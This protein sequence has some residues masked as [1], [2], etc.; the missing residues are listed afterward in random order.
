MFL[1][2]CQTS[3]ATLKYGCIVLPVLSAI[4]KHKAFKQL[5]VKNGE[6]TISKGE[7]YNLDKNNKC[8]LYILVLK[9]LNLIKVSEGETI[10]LGKS[11]TQILETPFFEIVGHLLNFG[12]SNVLYNSSDSATIVLLERHCERRDYLKK[13]LPQINS[14]FV[15]AI[16]FMPLLYTLHRIY[17]QDATIQDKLLE[18][19]NKVINAIKSSLIDYGIDLSYFV[20]IENSNNLVLAQLSQCFS[21]ATYILSQSN[22]IPKAGMN[23]I[24]NMCTELPTLNFCKIV[25]YVEMINKKYAIKRIVVC[26]DVSELQ[27]REIQKWKK[28]WNLSSVIFAVTTAIVK[29]RIES[30]LGVSCIIKVI[31]NLYD[32]KMIKTMINSIPTIDRNEKML[33]IAGP[34]QYILDN[35]SI[36]KTSNKYKSFMLKW[37]EVLDSNHLLISVSNFWVKGEANTSDVLQQDNDV[38]TILP[39]E[40][41]LE[42]A[43]NYFMWRRPFSMLLGASNAGLLPVKKIM[44]HT[45]F[46]FEAGFCVTILNTVDYRI[47]MANISDLGDAISLE[48]ESWSIGMRYT[49]HDIQKRISDDSQF[50]TFILEKRGVVLA[51]LYTQRI[52]AI[53]NI[54]TVTWKTEGKIND[55]AGEILQL[56]RINARKS[57]PIAAGTLLRNFAINVAHALKIEN[58]C[59]VTRTTDYGTSDCRKTYQQ[60]ISDL[61]EKKSLN[62]KKDRGL[63]F[64]T[65]SGASM[66]KI[67]ENWRPED[68]ENEGNG[69]LILYS[70]NNMICS[71]SAIS[72]AKIVEDIQNS[73]KRIIIV[74]TSSDQI[75]LNTTW[76]DLGLNSLDIYRTTASISEAFNLALDSS[77]LFNYST[78]AS[79]TSHIVSM[80]TN[81]LTD[82]DNSGVGFLREEQVLSNDTEGVYIQGVSLNFPGCNTSLQSFWNMSLSGESISSK[83]P[84]NRWDETMIDPLLGPVVSSDVRRRCKFGAFLDDIDYFDAKYFGISENEAQNMDPHQRILLE[85]VDRALQDA[86]YECEVHGK[87]VGVFLGICDEDKPCRPANVPL[88][89]YDANAKSN[90]TAAGR[91]SY[92]YDWTGPC[93]SFDTACSSSLVALHAALSA[94]EKGECNIAVV[95]ATHL[96]L[97]PYKHVAYAKAAMTSSRGLCNSFDDNADGYLRGEGCGVLILRNISS[98]GKPM[99][100]PYAVINGVQIAQDG[101]TASLTAP[102]S[103]AQSRVIQ[104]TLRQSGVMANQV[105][106]IETH[107]TGTVLGDPIEID[108]IMNC[109]INNAKRENDLVVGCAKSNIGHLEA[110]A[111]IVGVIK[112]ILVLNSETYPP[113]ANLNILN[114]NIKSLCPEGGIIFPTEAKSK[115]TSETMYAAVSSFGYAGTIAHAILSQYSDGKKSLHESLKHIFPRKKRE[116]T[117]FLFTGQGSQYHNMGRFLFDNDEVF[118]A[119]MQ[120]CSRILE[121]HLDGIS[122][123]DMMYRDMQFNSKLLNMTKYSQPAIF[124]LG[125]SLYQVWTTRGKHADVLLGHSVGELIAACV[126]GVISLENGLKLVAKR[127]SIMQ[128]CPNT[129]GTMCAIKCPKHVLENKIENFSNVCIACCNGPDDYVISGEKSSIMQAI[130]ELNVPSTIL[131]VSHAFHSN[132]MQPAEINLLSYLKDFEFSPCQIPLSSTLT[133]S[134]LRDTNW[135]QH[136]ARQLTQP[137]KFHSALQACLEYLR[138]VNAIGGDICF[139]EVS[140]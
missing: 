73:L 113:I 97:S 57:A 19:K 107:G 101:R 112:T 58:I 69:V 122:I 66:L 34:P 90:A 130:Q 119:S 125:W 127:G 93:V 65:G 22:A 18:R 98:Y 53:S 116:H 51:I 102:S 135:N 59:A 60:Y 17:M 48:K 111:G 72:H 62:F 131:N 109:Y 82:N 123:I 31:E 15:D 5:L 12:W 55:P 87:N 16:Y 67:L 77:V 2:S 24:Y 4:Q 23:T 126:A 10:F 83:V 85:A 8:E 37:C 61:N 103:L 30:V 99:G 115:S 117:I 104:S 118:R 80:T 95:A 46:F 124:S 64:H 94:I 68:V 43:L 96:I 50:F 52:N 56:L 81:T 136:F 106:F 25:K 86:E 91:I 40:R 49:E 45:P 6:K 105:A 137:V 33:F 54:G 20:K 134:I 7:V 44:G 129:G 38:K 1:A 88:N 108:A 79:L 138:G 70:L 100:I 89:V 132:Q 28:L 47:R 42:N 128:A 11:L 21:Y 76:F 32:P 14:D 27:I 9:S 84:G 133:G 36:G 41:T 26:L 92:I 74:S 78:L 110:A 63:Y 139:V 114:K 13:V 35:I 3:V 29:K 120:K 121:Q 140:E 39:D 75:P 71:D